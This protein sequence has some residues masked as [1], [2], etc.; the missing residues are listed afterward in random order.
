M[1]SA[2]SQA[3]SEPL[4]AAM[5]QLSEKPHQGVPSSNPALYLGHEV[6]KSTTALGLR[7]AL[8]LERVKSRYTGKERDTESGNDY[9]GARYFGSSMGRFMSP[10]WSDDPD[11]VPFADLENPQSLNL[12]AFAGNNPL[13]AVDE[14]GHDYYLQGG[15]QCGQNG[16]NCDSSGYVLGSDGNRQVVTDAQTQNGGAILSQGANGGVN[17]T[18]GTGTFAG[19]FFDASPNAVSATV[20]ADPSIAPSASAF[21][22]QTNAYNQA[23]MPVLQAQAYTLDLVAGVVAWGPHLAVTAGCLAA[24]CSNSKG[25]AAQA[26]VGGMRRKPGTLG[27]FGS[28]AAENKIA[29]AI[30]K[31][32]PGATREE[33]HALLQEGSR[34]AGRAL[35]FSEGLQYVRAALGLVE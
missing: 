15:N 12:Y 16:V 23:A 20:S 22:D 8:H 11:P 30:L 17:V 24:N 9:F 14:D 6:C 7:A 13:S 34:D 10:D 29:K 32:A 3:F 4:L 5:P 18:I 26:A 31:Q 35:T 28:T 27:Q 25:G 1:Q 2:L 19:E 21:I 33:V